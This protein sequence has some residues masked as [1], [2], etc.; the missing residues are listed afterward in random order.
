MLEKVHTHESELSPLW[1][2]HCYVGRTPT[3]CHDLNS[4]PDDL[5]RGCWEWSGAE[6]LFYECSEQCLRVLAHFC[7]SCQRKQLLYNGFATP[8]PFPTVNSGMTLTHPASF[9]YWNSTSNHHWLTFSFFPY[10][11]IKISCYYYCVFFFFLFCSTNVLPVC[12]C[13][14]G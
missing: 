8:S 11:V 7:W 13:G 12:I 1:S 3:K 9:C 14:G 10:I 4:V 6:P 5:R 2:R